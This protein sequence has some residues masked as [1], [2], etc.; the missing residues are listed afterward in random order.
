MLITTKQM[1]AV[2]IYYLDVIAAKANT[3]SEAAEAAVDA[4]TKAARASG[5]I[6]TWAASEAAWDT[7]RAAQ[8][9]DLVAMFPPVLEG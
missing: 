2:E 8:V 3:V 9:A 5:E 4:A 1:M 6:A 7:E